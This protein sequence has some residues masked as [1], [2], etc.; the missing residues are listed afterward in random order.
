[1]EEDGT[2]MVYSVYLRCQSKETPGA[3]WEE[4]VTTERVN[5]KETVLD[6]ERSDGLL[7]P[8]MC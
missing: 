5:G 3:W 2:A 6:L 7:T 8:R 1:M 4:R